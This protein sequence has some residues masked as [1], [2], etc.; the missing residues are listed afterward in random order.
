MF[1]RSARSAGVRSALAATGATALLTGTAVALVAVPT[2]AQAA[3]AVQC[4]VSYSVT[5]DWGSGFG[6]TVTVKNL[7]AAWTSWTL[8]YSYAGNQTL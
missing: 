2:S 4:Q 8:G 1:P 3:S 5:S 7:G 6:T